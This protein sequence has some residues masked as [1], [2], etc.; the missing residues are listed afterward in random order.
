MVKLANRRSELENRRIRLLRVQDTLIQVDLNVVGLLDPRNERLPVTVLQNGE[1]FGF[2]FL[3]AAGEGEFLSAREEART[4]KG[5]G[6]TRRCRCRGS[7]GGKRRR[8]YASSRRSVRRVL[9]LRA[10]SARKNIRTA[11]WSRRKRRDAPWEGSAASRRPSGSPTRRRCKARRGGAPCR[12][13]EEHLRD[14]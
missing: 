12:P 6:R 1:A 3:E 9:V 2:G 14:S 11:H 10:K 8:R 13:T 5:I 4:G 7:G